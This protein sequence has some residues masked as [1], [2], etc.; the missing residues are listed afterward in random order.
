MTGHERR[1]MNARPERPTAVHGPNPNGGRDLVV[2]D[3]H[4]GFRTLEHALDTLSFDASTDRLFSVG[5]LIDR[6]PDSARALEWLKS[7]RI[8]AA[9][10]GNHEQMLLERIRAAEGREV[11]WAMHRWFP[12]E[13][14]REQHGRWRA[15]IEAMPV[16]AT[17]RTRH[18][19]VG[20][21]HA[22]PTARHWETTLAK[23]AAGDSSTGNKETRTPV[24]A[25]LC[26]RLSGHLTHLSTPRTPGIWTEIVELVRS[27]R[28]N[29][30]FVN[31]LI[32]K[33][34]MNS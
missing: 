25:R 2:G 30:I 11:S 17:V 23:L 13:V 15:M 32:V 27:L 14:D 24:P 22:S 31:L 26:A 1:R 34:L 8:T 12:R 18:G 29:G 16:A 3:V 28:E 6:G 20:L 19:Y 4:G 5:D 33:T 10:R 7:G 9:V 21:V